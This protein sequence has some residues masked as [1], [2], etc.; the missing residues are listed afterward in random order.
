[1]A[2][3]STQT[4]Y[5]PRNSYAVLSCGLPKG[6][7]TLK[8]RVPEERDKTSTGNRVLIGYFMVAGGK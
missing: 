6:R 7:H 4:R 1:M 3:R 8:V 5:V 2:T